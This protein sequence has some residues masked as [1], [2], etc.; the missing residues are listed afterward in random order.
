MPPIHNGGESTAVFRA[1]QMMCRIAVIAAACC[2]PH[3]AALAL[4]QQ[5]APADSLQIAGVAF[6]SAANAT[7][8]LFPVTQAM[9][10]A[11][12]KQKADTAGPDLLTRT[13]VQAFRSAGVPI[14]EDEAVRTGQSLAFAFDDEYQVEDRIRDSYRVITVLSAQ[15]LTIDFRTQQVVSAMPVSFDLTSVSATPPD[16]AFRARIVRNL[17]EQF[18]DAS[19]TGVFGR[20]AETFRR[21]V[22]ASEGGCLVRIGEATY[23][24]ST[25]DAVQGRFG[26]DT[27]RFARSVMSLLGRTWAT[28]ARQALLPNGNSQARAKMQ[29]RFANGEVFNLNIPSADYEISFTDIATKRGIA[30]QNSAIRVEGIGM[31]FK[32][33][34]SDTELK[35]PVT[36]GTFSTVQ[37][38]T[39]PAQSPPIDSWVAISNTLKSLTAGV[40]TAA[41]AGDRKWLKA[42]DSEKTSVS[43]LPEWVAKRCGN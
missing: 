22:P 3:S 11:A 30:G 9:L 15:L 23:D 35:K 31:Q 21:L 28:T 24:P 27:A 38:D 10:T 34:V 17:T 4:T 37:L 40:G 41:R 14:R 32:L 18:T 16:D 12:K 7:D 25:I 20:A 39:L 43:T 26:T 33:R 36:G 2:L 19:A 8:A 29:G 42:N 5:A 1:R 6:L 13:M